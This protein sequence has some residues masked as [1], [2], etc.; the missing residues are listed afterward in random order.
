[1][2][3]STNVNHSYRP[4]STLVT[5]KYTPLLNIQADKPDK[6]AIDNM[7]NNR[8]GTFATQNIQVDGLTFLSAQTIDQLSAGEQGKSPALVVISSNRSKWIKARYDNAEGIVQGILPVTTHFTSVMD[9]RALQAGAV[10]LFLPIRLGT[11]E[12]ANRNVYVFVT[13]NEFQ[14]YRTELA[15]TGVIVVAWRGDGVGRLA[16][17]GASRYAALEFFKY[18]NGQNNARCSRIWMIDDN[19][20]YIRAFPG[21]GVV[22]GALGTGF[23]LGFKGTTNVTADGVYT[24]RIS[25]DDQPAA[26]TAAPATAPLL[27]QAVLWNVARFRET[28]YSFSPYFIASAED[29]SLTK[30]LNNLADT[31]C[32]YYS[33]CE[34]FKGNVD[35]YDDAGARSK[36]RTDK[37]RR[38][39]LAACYK[40]RNAVPITSPDVLGATDLGAIITAARTAAKSPPR[41]P[42]VESETIE[43]T[44]SKAIEQLMSMA[45]TLKIA[46]PAAVFTPPA[47]A[48]DSK[49]V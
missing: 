33:A 5:D 29:S 41:I 31:N 43:Q 42:E 39:L 6:A 16:G 23:G 2:A 14:Q 22:E 35:V 10:P 38:V 25:V 27:Q 34:V 11:V 47:V 7:V 1:M 13:P 15:G 32:R 17:F 46:L 26:S 37:F 40:G 24:S 20:A 30:F 36:D 48:I 9:T 19:V 4:S 21:W 49:I 44:Y 3:L 18:I 28:G 45:L 12:A 8:I